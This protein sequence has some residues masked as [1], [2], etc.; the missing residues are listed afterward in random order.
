ML[1]EVFHTKQACSTLKIH[2]GIWIQRITDL[3]RC[4]QSPSS[5]VR[6]GDLAQPD[7]PLLKERLCSGTCSSDRL[8]QTRGPASVL[9]CLLPSHTNT[10]TLKT[11]ENEVHRAKSVY[12]FSESRETI[13][14]CGIRL[15][16]S[17]VP[18]GQVHG[19]AAPSGLASRCPH[20]N[21]PSY[22]EVLIHGAGDEHVAVICTS[23]L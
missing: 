23:R 7:G 22:L 20:H 1:I 11:S 12:T 16:G 9:L 13:K 21:A 14:A 19:G 3:P 17:S 15:A 8:R 18:S 10:G 2:R 6:R 4:P 5:A